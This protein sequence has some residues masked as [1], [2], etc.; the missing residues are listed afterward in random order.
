MTEAPWRL[1]ACELGEGI[2]AGRFTCLDAME[3]VVER[4]PARNGD[5][6][7]IVYDYSDSALEQARDADAAL[8]RGEDRGPLHGIPVTIKEN[9]DVAGTP[10]PNGVAA[11]EGVIA[12]DDAPVVRNLRAAGAIIVGRTNTPELSMRATTDNPLHGRTVNPWDAEASPGGSS[13]GASAAAAAGFGPIHHGNDIGGSL[14]F[15]SFACGLATLKPG[16]GRVP[17]YNPSACEERGLLAQLMSVQGAICREV[18]DVA[19]ATRIMARGDARDPHWMP[20][21]FDGWPA[22]SPLRVAV[23]TESHGYPV[24]PGIVA[25]VERSADWLSDA[26]YAVERVTTPSIADPA[27]EWCDVAVHEFE[28]TLGP[29]A[30]AYGSDAIRAI[31]EDFKTL[32][33][34]VD[35]DGYRSGIARRTAYLREW[36]VFLQRYP[37]V[38]CP[39]MMRPLYAWNY[40]SQSTECMHDLFRSAIYSYAV[41]YL[42]LPAG[43]VPAGLVEA[44]PAGV[45]I[46]GRRFREDLI[47]DAMAALEARQ[48]IM[49][50]ALWAREDDAS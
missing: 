6:N 11:L 49:V 29:V 5:I 2:R 38:L 15:P 9:V 41:N 23:T 34:M 42:G 19:L 10:T 26:G 28:A 33:S 46:I 43:V 20:V 1:S 30:Q 48:G 35:C 4:I 37:L 50:H 39:F 13:G 21:P 36:N 16:L 12:P 17:A 24:H 25:A 45:Q 32:G 44:L 31:F 3:S 14:R 27:R 47:L 7:A 8:A 40:D 18:R 22:E